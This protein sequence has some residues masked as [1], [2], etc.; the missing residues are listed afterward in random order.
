MAINAKQQMHMKQHRRISIFE[1]TH[2]DNEHTAGSKSHIV[3][4]RVIYHAHSAI[5]RG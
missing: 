4:V 2:I 5:A 1:S 3:R